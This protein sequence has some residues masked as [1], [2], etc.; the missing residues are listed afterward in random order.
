MKKTLLA[1]ALVFAW[2][3]TASALPVAP[4]TGAQTA[5]QPGLLHLVRDRDHH[6]GSSHHGGDRHRGYRN[7]RDRYHGWHRYRSRPYDWR[8]RRCVMAGPVW[9]CP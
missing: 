1:A 5:D 4:H 9:V 6:R 8:S 7:H 3:G 2:C